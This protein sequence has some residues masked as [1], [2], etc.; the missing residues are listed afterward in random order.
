MLES[1]TGCRIETAD[2]GAVARNVRYV[3]N[4][5]E[6]ERALMAVLRS[7][8]AFK[9]GQAEV[10][11]AHGLSFPQYNILR[12]LEASE[13]GRNSVSGVSKIM[14]V[15]VANM[16][17]LAKGLERQGFI[18]RTSHPNDERVTVLEITEKGRSAVDQIREDKDRHIEAVLEGFADEE[19]EILLDLAR[20]I[21][22][23]ARHHDRGEA[24][25]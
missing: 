1:A 3:S 19:K 25:P 11:R 2:E 12:V 7:G 16:T 18:L 13:D 10:C 23:N 9:R 6:N 5:T 4:Q 20:R 15:P 14:L 24:K 22:R 21:V 17:G 8:E